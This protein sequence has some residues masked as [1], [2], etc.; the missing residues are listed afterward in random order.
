MQGAPSLSARKGMQ[1]LAGR[2]DHVRASGYGN[3]GGCQF[4]DHSAPRQ[5]SARLA[6]HSLDLRRDRRYHIE[7]LGDGILRGGRRVEPVNVGQ[8][9]KAVCRHHAGHARSEPV[10]VAVTDLGSGHGV[11]L[12]DDRDRPELE[13]CLD[14]VSRVEVAPSLLGIAERDKDLRRREASLAENGLIGM[15]KVDLS[16]RGRGLRLFKPE[17]TRVEAQRTPAER[18]GARRDE[19]HVAPIGLQ[20]SHI[21]ADGFQPGLL[22]RACRA[23]GQKGRADLDGD[24]PRIAPF[25][26]R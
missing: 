25:R 11:I 6:S 8:K 1:V 20:R 9:H 23:I 21:V 13:K 7:P 17:R 22:Q 5:L 18:N 3:L 12:I 24:A 4:R 10:I 14:R 2:D 19:D 16:D 26:P 15:R